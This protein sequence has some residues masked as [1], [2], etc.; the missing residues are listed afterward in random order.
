MLGNYFFNLFLVTGQNKSALFETGVSGVVDSVIAQLEARKFISHPKSG[1]LM[2][3]EDF[4]MSQ[5]LDPL[6]VCPAHQGPL[7]ASEAS[8]G[9]QAARDITLST[10]RRVN[11]TLLSDRQLTREMF[12][13]SYVDEFTLYTPDNIQNCTRLLIKRAREFHDKRSIHE[14]PMC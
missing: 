4:F 1:P 9:I 8:Q 6:V 12:E 2:L 10:I 5:S 13:Q 11:E 7:T 3:K 14:S